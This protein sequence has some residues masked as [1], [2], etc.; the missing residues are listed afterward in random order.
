MS[1]Q[2]LLLTLLAFIGLASGYLALH[3][4]GSHPAKI[5]NS[6]NYTEGCRACD[7]NRCPAD[8]S[9][10]PLG[11]VPDV[12]GCCTKGVCARLGGESCWNASIPELPKV[13]KNEGLCSRNY[14]C[15]LRD[16]LQP[17]DVPEATC[18]CMEQ[19]LACGTNNRT[20]DTPCFLHEEA[21]RIRD[22]LLELQHLGPC[23]SR[24]RIY[25]GPK[26]IVAT[27]GQIIAFDCEAKGF[28]LPH[29]YWEFHSA[30]G[31]KFFRL[32]Y[33]KLENSDA[34]QA[35]PENLIQTSWLQL[36]RFE[37]YHVGTYHCIAKNPY[38][39]A[40]ASSQVSMR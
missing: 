21:I 28:P 4:R 23:P 13:R 9:L 31:S 7:I 20:Y 27:T 14:F 25:S 35:E 33:N 39:E 12:C 26:D 11:F 18:S 19:S 32:P 6:L 1:R 37:T 30:D 16:D 10:C 34:K 40:S 5:A 29:I 8:A 22:S 36:G 3:S 24:P 17:E 2:P 15:K 38:G